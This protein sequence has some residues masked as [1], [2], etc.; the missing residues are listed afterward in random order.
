MRCLLPGCR[1][2]SPASGYEARLVGLGALGR[3]ML[4][5]ACWILDS[6]VLAELGRRSRLQIG[7]GRGKMEGMQIYSD[8]ARG[9]VVC[10]NP[11]LRVTGEARLAQVL[12]EYTITGAGLGESLDVGLSRTLGWR[13]AVRDGGAVGWQRLGV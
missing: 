11:R 3:W 5:V 2:S 10:L 8:E 13:C 6:L 1:G 4:D 12:A 9:G 7:N